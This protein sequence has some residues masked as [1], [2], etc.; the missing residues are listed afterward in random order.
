MYIT[1][2]YA[3]CVDNT[4]SRLASKLVYLFISTHVEEEWTRYAE[5]MKDMRRTEAGIMVGF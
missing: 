1:G 5:E 4:D 2:D 3:I